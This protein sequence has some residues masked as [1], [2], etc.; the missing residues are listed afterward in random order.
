M[1]ALREAGQSFS[2]GQ[3]NSAIRQNNLTI[4]QDQLQVALR[5]CVARHCYLRTND[6]IMQATG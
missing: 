1:S 3:G 6:T 5:N 2:V 4:Q